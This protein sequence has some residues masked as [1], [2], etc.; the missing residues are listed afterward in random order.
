MAL[1]ESTKNY[2]DI[3]SKLGGVGRGYS[4]GDLRGVFA[5]VPLCGT[6]NRLIHAII[7]FVFVAVNYRKDYLWKESPRF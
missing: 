4:Y 7:I 6:N 2:S 5:I 1:L 3:V